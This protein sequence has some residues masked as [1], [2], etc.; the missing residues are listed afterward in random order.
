MAGV[1]DIPIV[2]PSYHLKDWALDCQRTLNLYP[3]II[4][5]GNGP[6]VSALLPT[7]GLVERFKLEGMIR[8]LYALS[9]FVLCV[10]GQSLYRIGLDDT[11][12]KIGDI[13]GEDLVF[14]ADDSIHVMIVGQDAYKYTIKT[15][16]LEKLIIDDETGFF[17]ARDVTFLDSRF[18]WTVPNSGQ[19]QWST[20]LNTDTD[21]LSYATAE[22]RSDNLVRTVA[23]N[24]QL[25][26]IGEK[27]TEIWNSTGSNDLPYRRM[28]GAYIPTGCVAKN[29]LCQFGGSLVWLSQSEHGN[30][31]IVMTEGYSAKRISNH[32]I[33]SEISNYPKIDDAYSFAYQQDG[34]A[35]FVISFPSVK[36]TWCFDAITNMWHERSFYNAETFTHEHHR[37]N[38]HCFFNNEHLVGDRESGVI[39]R[40]CQNCKS[41]NRSM[42][43]R[44]RITP[45]V[46]P[47]GLRLRFSELELIMQTGQMDNSDPQIMLSWSD[48][49][50]QSWSPDIQCGIGKIGE[51]SHRVVFRRLGQSFNRVFRLRMSDAA[52]FVIV[53]AKAKVI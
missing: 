7:P 49:R 23:A 51:F 32:A 8:G 37:A 33:E 15:R 22:A 28:S 2:G 26:L 1:I 17:G 20:L 18:I 9:D 11:K 48:D 53:G 43:L 38:T 3:Q 42:I 27:T 14:F 34:H 5:S 36:K 31:Q 46:N 6:S 41:D 19:I 16:E 21:A 10:S 30:A 24:G 47:Q 45:V 39:Y 44:E 52:Q 4:E 29:S 50:G 40:L 12:I 13:S 35:F 25:W